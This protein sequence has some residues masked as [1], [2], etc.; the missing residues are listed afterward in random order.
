MK[1]AFA[2]ALTGLLA[3]AEVI[4]IEESSAECWFEEN[5]TYVDSCFSLYYWHC[6]EYTVDPE[7]SCIVRTFSNTQITSEFEQIQVAYWSYGVNNSWIQKLNGEGDED[8]DSNDSSGDFDTFLSKLASPKKMI[9]KMLKQEKEDPENPH[10][11]YDGWVDPFEDRCYLIDSEA[12]TYDLETKE[13]LNKVMGMC[14]FKIQ[15]TNQNT[16]KAL[17]VK[18]LRDG[19]STLLASAIAIAATSSLLF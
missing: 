3:S 7:S 9:N 11:Y 14:G 6:D 16:F 8:E 1:S 12:E 19:A 17:N 13:Q 10:S 18:V 4:I 2:L 15:F 5:A